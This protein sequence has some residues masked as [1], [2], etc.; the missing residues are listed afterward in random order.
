MCVKIIGDGI[1]CKYD[2]SKPL[3]E[4]VCDNRRVII[5]YEAK[6]PDVEKF[7]HEMERLC[8]TGIST[9]MT[10]KIEHN[11]DIKGI[12]AKKQLKR[13]EKDLDLNEAIKL[14]VKIQQSTDMKLETL[15]NFCRTR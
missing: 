13:L 1:E 9:N 15:S 5:N 7:I 2:S 14:L 3:E 8:K 10:V 6:D 11:N 12:K 4:Q